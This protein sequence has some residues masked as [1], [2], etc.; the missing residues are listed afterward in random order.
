MQEEDKRLLKVPCNCESRARDEAEKKSIEQEISKV[1]EEII[2][3]E[4]GLIELD[5]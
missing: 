5:E 1:Y 4:Q 2:Q 3:L